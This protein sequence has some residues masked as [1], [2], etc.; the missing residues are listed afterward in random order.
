MTAEN[1]TP[2]ERPILYS[3]PMARAYFADM[4]T[5]TRRICNVTTDEPAEAWRQSDSGD[6]YAV[7]RVATTAG[8]GVPVTGMIRC[9]YG[10]PGD[11]LWGRE[12]HAFI[13]CE[14]DEPGAFSGKDRG[15]YSDYGEWFKVSY[16]A[17]GIEHD[18]PNFRPSIHMP[19]WASR[20]LAE[21]VSVRIERLQSISEADAKAD[22]CEPRI[23]SHGP[24]ELSS[25]VLGYKDLWMQIN[26]VQ[27]WHD[28][29]WVWVVE[30]KRCE[31]SRG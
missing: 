13:T 25:Y 31:V 7:S 26:G 28:N 18:P 3:A 16:F 11:R 6:F 23:V 22:G 29:P 19:R 5:Q 10:Q 21:V 4:K 1:Q 14:P 24:P 12:T 15:I 30:F 20:M 17:D 2:K 9:P 27:S 8:L